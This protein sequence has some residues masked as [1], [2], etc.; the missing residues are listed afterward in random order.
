VTRY[1]S[2]REGQWVRGLA[3]DDRLVAYLP[4]DESGRAALGV[5]EPSASILDLSRT[6][7]GVLQGHVVLPPGASRAHVHA[8][9]EDLEL[10]IDTHTD[11]DGNYV[12]RGVPAG[13]TWTLSADVR[14][15]EVRYEASF[16][17]VRGSE[18]A[19][20]VLTKVR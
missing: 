16:S 18:V 12:L 2:S 8:S 4:A 13:W 17:G 19:E 9:A 10:G 11:A 3:A 15:G 7:D 14:L 20:L 5:A 1:F 6:V